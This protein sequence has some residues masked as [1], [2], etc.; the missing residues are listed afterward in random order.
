M[1]NQDEILRAVKEAA[2]LLHEFPVES[3]TSSDLLTIVEE[4]DVP[5]M[6]RP[7]DSLK[8]ATVSIDG[9]SGILVKAGLP[10]SVQRFTLA[11]ELG[12]LL[13]DHETEFDEEIGISQRA[14]GSE[15]R[16]VRE[17]AAD[18][19][20]SELL[21]PKSLLR[22]NMDRQGWNSL[23]LR[24]SETIY[25]LSLRLG[26]SFP[27]TCWAL[28]EHDILDYGLANEYNERKDVVK[29][30]KSSFV[31]D[32]V[33][34]NPRADV[35]LLT[36]DDAG[37][38]LKASED[39]VF[40]VELEEKSSSGYLWNVQNEGSSVRIVDEEISQG[41][42]YGSSSSRVVYLTYETPGIHSLTIQHRRPWNEKIL[43]EIEISID[44]WGREEEGLPRRIRKASLDEAIA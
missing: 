4:L 2:S 40:V 29:E 10:R 1:T 34:R 43:D 8:G 5:V 22:R 25:Q 19:F 15:N 3:G 37:T 28:V 42:N 24:N 39:D 41:E 17:I 31:P 6:Y 21:A 35:W 27:A 33:S 7:L 44:N 9:T 30:A 13:L 36:E 32:S 38:H 14:S 16:P 23:D 20:A 26:L 12:H 18:T 11:H